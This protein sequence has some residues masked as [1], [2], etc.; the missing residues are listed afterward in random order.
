MNDELWLAS[1][2]SNMELVVKN[3]AEPAGPDDPLL[4][5]CHIPVRDADAP[6]SEVEPQWDV[7]AHEFSAVAYHFGRELRHALDKPVSMIN[8]S[9]GATS[10]V[11]WLP[12]EVVEADPHWD[13]IAAREAD[14]ISHYE[15]ALKKRSEVTNPES[16]W[17]PPN[18]Y[19]R[20]PGALYNGM[21][22]PLQR[23]PIRGVIW[24]QGE[25]DA[26][27]PEWYATLF[28][29]LIRSWRAAW[30]RELPFLFV[31]LSSF[32]GRPHEDWALLRDVQR[33]VAQTVPNTA[34]VVSLDV[35]EKD[36]IHPKRK[37]PVGERLA[38][39]ARALVYNQPVAWRGPTLASV[40][41]DGRTLR[42]DNAGNGLR[43]DGQPLRG[44]EVAGADGA[45][46][47]VNAVITGDT[48]TITSSGEIRKIRY[49]WSSLTNAN[50]F[51]SHALPAE[52]FIKDLP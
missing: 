23:L 14:K 2:Q 31:Q 21:I 19:V 47:A 20:R 36:D 11:S 8:A 22:A 29:A 9:L 38:R 7:P 30:G 18:P 25:G 24:Y 44:L 34:M 48:I 46:H 28:P 33:N 52:P 4:R 51:N 17:L 15:W 35:G 27:F 39:A 45:F 26:A 42:F 1:G 5:L 37:Q 6:C 40:E 13:Q 3:A 32:G 50:L 41:R 10:I 16:I 49:A 12:R 43:T